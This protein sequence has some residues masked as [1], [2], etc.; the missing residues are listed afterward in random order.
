MGERKKGLPEPMVS[1]PGPELV[2]F[3]TNVQGGIAASPAQPR[4]QVLAL[5]LSSGNLQVNVLIPERAIA[6][7]KRTIEE[8][9]KA[10]ATAKAGIVLS[11]NGDGPADLAKIAADA[12]DA[13]KKLRGQG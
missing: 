6:P 13:Q 3:L 8:A 9:E 5:G 12:A 4:E 10:L 11:G 2:M 1:V 7:F